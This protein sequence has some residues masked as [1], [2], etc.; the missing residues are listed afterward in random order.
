MN[1]LSSVVRDLLPTMRRKH[2]FRALITVS[3]FAA[4]VFTGAVQAGAEEEQLPDR[5]MLRLEVIIGNVA[6]LRLDEQSARWH[7]CRFS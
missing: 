6:P 7:L 3:A 2:L 4:F 5:F 1:T